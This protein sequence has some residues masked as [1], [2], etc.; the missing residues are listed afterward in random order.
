MRWLGDV[1]SCPAF[2][3]LSSMG[4]KDKAQEAVGYR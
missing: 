3:A 1:L 4:S 2:P